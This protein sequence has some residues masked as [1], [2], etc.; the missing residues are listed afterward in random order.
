ML[1]A[2]DFR[3]NFHLPLMV[4]PGLKS[5]WET[6]G[7]ALLPGSE[8]LVRLRTGTMSQSVPK[9]KLQVTL[10]LSKKYERLVP[11]GRQ[12][13]EAKQPS[14]WHAR[15]LPET[16]RSHWRSDWT[17]NYGPELTSANSGQDAVNSSKKL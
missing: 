17:T 13:A 4:G 7:H 8:S 14:S 6:Y 15:A 3:Y 11:L 9:K 5:Y 12:Q 10:E 2:P 16:R 1:L